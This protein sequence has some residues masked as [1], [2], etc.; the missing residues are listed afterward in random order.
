MAVT[1][2][3][4]GVLNFGASD[5]LVTGVYILDSLRWVGATAT[6]Q[7]CLVTD[8]AGNVLFT[9][10]ADGPNFTDGWIFDQKWV[11]GITVSSMNSGTLQVY[12]CR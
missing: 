2:T 9:G 3:G 11:N 5:D 1:G 7:V 10:L 6:G 12:L 4:T 8:A